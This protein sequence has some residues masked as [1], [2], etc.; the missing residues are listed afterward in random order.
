MAGLVDNALN[1][2]ANEL[3]SLITHIGI[4]TADP[5]TTG[6]SPAD[7]ARQAVTWDA[8][9]GGD[10]SLAGP[11]NFTGGAASG[12][13][14]FVGL[15]GSAGTGTPPTGG[16]FYGSFALVGDQTF[17]AAGEYTVNDVTINGAPA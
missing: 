16:T 2:M 10:I 9:S 8:A 1:A 7:S 12:A 11:E 17:N 13:A 5:G 14:E 6:T 15:W 4:H 3:A